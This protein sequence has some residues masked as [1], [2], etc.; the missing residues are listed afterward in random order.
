GRTGVEMEARTGASVA[1]LTIYDMCKA[2]S[3]DMVIREVRLMGKA[4]GKRDFQRIES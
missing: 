2:M 1:A 3:H 4:G